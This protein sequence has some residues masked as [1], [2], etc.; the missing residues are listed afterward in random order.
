MNLCSPS[1]LKEHREH[2]LF[3]LLLLREVEELTVLGR[4]LFTGT[5]L[6]VSRMHTGDIPSP[7]FYF[8]AFLSP[9]T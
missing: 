2:F 7:F 1:A 9:C 6:P 4:T 3:L 8:L 5:Y